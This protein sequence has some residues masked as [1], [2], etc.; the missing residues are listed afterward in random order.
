[1]S[2]IHGLTMPKWGLSMTEGKVVAWLVEEGQEISQGLE[3]V[4]IETDK[5]LSA[6][7]APISGVL[8]RQVAKVADVVPV[9]GLLGVLADA[10]IADSEIDQFIAKF[11]AQ[12]AL[13]H[14]TSQ[15]SG[16]VPE[17][18]EVQGQSL[19]YL[20]RGEGGEASLLLHGFGGDL[21][22]W[23]F[24]H[25]ELAAGRQVYALDLPGHGGSS[26]QVGSGTLD[27][28]AELL[29][30]FID[31]AGISRTHLVGHSMGGAVALKFAL[32]RPDRCVSLTLIAG[33]GLGT[34]ID[35][36]FVNGFISAS[37][38][39]QIQPYIE[40][41]FANPR[42]VGRQLIENFLR[43]K[44]LDGVELAL[45]TIANQFC[46]LG[47]QTVVLRDRLSH[48]QMPVLVIWGA[49]DRILPVSQAQDLPENIRT[50]ILPGVGHMVHMEAATKVNRLV[51]SFWD[52]ASPQGH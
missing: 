14:T 10:S 8:R 36:E 24:N 19:S 5:T 45:R 6:V 48:L 46:P 35:G 11:Q 27:G 1:M 17:V 26:K 49:E 22:S 7:E 31:A 18:V 4:E 39:K 3:M 20:K 15:A 2:S 23:L 29:H 41:L 9:T 16:P 38:R 25:E 33:A 13:A 47:K 21:N 43:Y 50:E 44:R 42:L 34:E 12:V 51:R 52:S 40:R 30:S 32:A 37:R 28:F